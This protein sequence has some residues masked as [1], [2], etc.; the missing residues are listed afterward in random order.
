M[1]L[2]NLEATHKAPKNQVITIFK[3]K[4]HPSCDLN[5]GFRIQIDSDLD[6]IGNFTSGEEI[7]TI[8][9]QQGVNY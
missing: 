6:Y 1:R 5:I 8:K 3:V 9:D 7:K 4:E 2:R